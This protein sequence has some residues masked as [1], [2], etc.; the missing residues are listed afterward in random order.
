MTADQY[1]RALARFLSHVQVLPSGCW[2]WT[3]YTQ[4]S[5]DRDRHNKPAKRN[6]RPNL[7]G[8][9]RLNGKLEYAHRAAWLLYHGE[10]P[11]GYV[12][13][14]LECTNTLCVNPAHCDLGTQADNVQDMI[15][16][17]RATLWRARHETANTVLFEP[18]PF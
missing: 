17:G 10:I 8:R 13:R 3:A 9:F 7:R 5:A 12:V 15:D 1:S 18:V 2:L 6:T 14:H 11:E 16:A 4:D